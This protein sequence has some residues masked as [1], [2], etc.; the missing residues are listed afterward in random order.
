VYQGTLAGD[1]HPNSIEAS[2]NGLVAA[3]ASVIAPM[4][5]NLWVYDASGVRRALLSAAPG[6]TWLFERTLRFSGDGTRLFST[7]ETGM[8]IQAVP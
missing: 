2:W 7:S 6:G 4:N 5:A 8:R 3:M 1:S